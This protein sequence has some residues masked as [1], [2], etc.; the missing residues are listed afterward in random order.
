M[1]PTTEDHSSTQKLPGAYISSE[2]FGIEL[3]A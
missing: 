2:F 1:D 3:K